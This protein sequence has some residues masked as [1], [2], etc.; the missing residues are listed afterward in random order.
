MILV[1]SREKKW[2]HIRQYFRNHGI[3]YRVEKL[4]IADYA[5]EDCESLVIDRKQN[6]DELCNN[7]CTNDSGR[8]W[9]EIR[10]ARES[11]VKMIVLIE[12]GGKIKSIK[13]VASWKSKFSRVTGQRLAEEIYRMHIAYGVEFLFCDKRST[14]R[15]IIELLGGEKW[16]VMR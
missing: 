13:D 16:T 4:D 8:F 2:G 7:L 6:L 14:G 10:R 3:A 9:R 1:D 5:L 15:R 11:Q 12:H